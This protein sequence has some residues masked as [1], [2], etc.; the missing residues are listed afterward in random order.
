MVCSAGGPVSTTSTQAATT[1]SAT[2]TT[3]T[4]QTT[5]S[6]TSATTTSINTGAT[7]PTTTQGTT[8]TST[9]IT[10]QATSPSSCPA[11]TKTCGAGN[12]CADPSHC[13]SQ[14]GYCGVGPDYCGGLCCQ[15]GPCSGGGNPPSPTPP[16]PNPP[17]PTPGSP[18]S[19]A[20]DDSRLIAYVGNWQTCPTPQ[21][22]DAYT[23]MVIAFA[24][25][26]TWSP[27]QN[28]CSNTCN[29]APVVPICENQNRQ[30]LV[31]TWRAQGKKVILSFGGAGMG[32][33]WS[34]ELCYTDLVCALLSSYVPHNACLLRFDLLQETTT[35]VGTIVLVERRLLLLLLLTSSTI[36]GST[37]LILIMS[38]AMTFMALRAEGAPKG[39]P[40]TRTKRHKRS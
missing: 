2:T 18:P 16:T 5:S 35:T 39:L 22:T 38:T 21:Q 9:S 10:T 24:V 4:Q 17:S 29:V 33:S 40:I 19:I 20:A 7:V 23:H 25:S 11:E 3:T 6:S 8:T 34:G 15:N 13:C 36:K 14:W 28:S 31:D 32:G 30:D 26:Y 37:E 27:N 1:T 12:P